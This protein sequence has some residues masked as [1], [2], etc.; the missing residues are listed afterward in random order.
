MLKIKTR[1]DMGVSKKICEVGNLRQALTR[2]F[3][4]TFGG[5]AALITASKTPV[6]PL[7]HQQRISASQMRKQESL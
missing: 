2:L 5:R 4:F 1:F 6:Q 3:D 7:L